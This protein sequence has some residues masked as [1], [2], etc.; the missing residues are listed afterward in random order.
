MNESKRIV[1]ITGSADHSDRIKKLVR[2]LGDEW[3]PIFAANAA[4]ALVL[5]GEGQPVNAMVA[6]P[7][8]WEREE[9]N[10]LV[11]LKQ[12]FPSVA[13][14]SF[15]LPPPGAEATP[16]PPLKPGRSL[17]NANDIGSLGVVIDRSTELRRLLDN[18][19][20]R[21]LVNEIDRV[22][23]LP[24]TYL[25]LMQAA[26]KPAST[27]TDFVQIIQSDPG[28]SVRV[29]QLVNSSLFGLKSKVT[30]VQQAVNHLGL[31]LLKGLIASAHVFSAIDGSPTKVVSV[32]R[33]QLYSLRVG[34]LA[35]AMLTGRPASEDALTAGLLHNIGELVLA[36]ERPQQFAAVVQR[37]T[38]TGESRM[39]VE[40]AVFGAT[41][42]EVGAQLLMGW[43]IPFSIVEVAAYHHE[44][45][46]VSGGDVEVLAA[47]HSADALLGILTCGEPPGTLNRQFLERAGFAQQLPRWRELVESEVASWESTF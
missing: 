31:D 36:V 47:V 35:Q 5:L 23:S 6:E 14:V 21:Q 32:E 30:S 38:E 42:A 44:P 16:L 45:E 8:Q 37:C 26:S 17:A 7:E 9:N 1:F 3:T 28:T 25:A 39:T 2:D 27:V 46:R 43:G 19:S 22:P 29:L 41:H 33:C 10:L 15:S 40:R 12:K 11:E 13:P 34:R 18:D 20:V 4:E 24:T